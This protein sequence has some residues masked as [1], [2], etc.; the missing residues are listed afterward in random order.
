ML[1]K[2][3]P[4]LHRWSAQDGAE[5]Y[6]IHNWGQGYFSVG[7]DGQVVVHP[8]GADGPRMGLDDLVN[9][10][11]ARG[12]DLPV[13]LRFSDILRHRVQSLCGS[14]A[15]AIK[16]YGY[17]GRYRPVYPIKVNQQRDVVEELIEH[18]RPFALG[19]E[20]GSK[21]ELLVA[22]AHMDNPEGLIVCNG[23]KDVG[24]VETAMLAK[25]LGRHAILVVDR[26]DELETIIRASQRLDLRPHIGVRARLSARGAGKWVEST[27]DR[28]KFG[29][30]AAELVQAAER[31]RAAG[32]LDCLELLHFHIGSQI[33]SIRAIKDALR[34]ASRIYVEL[35]ALGAGLRMLDIG[36]GLAVDYDGSKTNWHS[37]TNYTLQEYA[38]DVV[39]A[40][41]EACDQRGMPHPDIVSE[42]GRALVAHH[43]LLVVDV[44]GSVRL[45][46]EPP[47]EIA[48]KHPNPVVRSLY[49]AWHS[50]NRKNYQE[51]YHDAVQL[52]EEAVS[53]F[54]LGY[55]DLAGRALAESIFWAIC[56]RCRRVLDTVDY[57]PEEFEGLA[58][59]L[60][61]TYYCNFSV[62]QSMPD[63]WAVKQLFPIVPIHRLDREPTRRGVLCD[64]TCDSDGKV[65]EF[66][67][68]HDTKR[69]LE[70]HDVPAGESYHLGF[71]LIGAYQ[72]ILGDLH[73]L[74]GDTHAIHVSLD[75]D[76]GYDIE[77][78]VEG[79]SVNEVLGYVQYGRSDLVRRVR[80]A[81]ERAVR[82]GELRLEELALLMRR[83]DEALSGYTY[84]SRG[85]GEPVD[86]LASRGFVSAQPGSGPALSGQSLSGQSLSGQSLSGQS[87]SGQ[88]AS[89]PVPSESAEA[90]GGPA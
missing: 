73:N 48:A 54:T 5:L 47:P 80:E 87:L 79:D 14:F 69:V 18:G 9:D 31:L 76:G 7:R 46:I 88:S 35:S 45:P 67:D 22:L 82:R 33:T 20:A 40:V 36:G 71:F 59:L 63:H 66:I 61:D 49:E 56:E 75:P 3:A 10:L 16:E 12:Y 51:C 41:Q 32:L 72:E 42:S 89:G 28:S 53:L 86:A 83:Y 85:N 50:L 55:L 74:F 4:D 1:S 77:R 90:N 44:L 11:V 81:G 64:L 34:E 25:K 21:P 15:A 38:N 24:Y 19:L 26:F 37:S 52:K 62:F 60:A 84:L 70:L 8:D 39:S 58:R 65:D 30:G 57:V 2:N 13:L 27:G 43:A 29:L 68:L 78:V 23:Y 17:G 6:Q